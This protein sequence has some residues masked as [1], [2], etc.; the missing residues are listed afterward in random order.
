M[1]FKQIKNEPEQTAG[2]WISEYINI[3]HPPSPS[4]RIALALRKRFHSALS[5][6]AGRVRGGVVSDAISL[7]WRQST[8]ISIIIVAARR[9]TDGR[10]TTGRNIQRTELT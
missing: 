10:T 8:H 4:S 2:V 1:K 9:A 7:G 3:T 6:K 5:V